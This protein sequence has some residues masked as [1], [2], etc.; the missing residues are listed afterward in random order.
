M[1][2]YIEAVTTL[3]PLTRPKPATLQEVLDL[4]D[5]LL[6]NQMMTKAQRAKAFD[7]VAA[8]AQRMAGGLRR[9]AVESG[10]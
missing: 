9:S 7:E 1:R 8:T 3:P 6:G 5:R 4:M 2:K 10:E